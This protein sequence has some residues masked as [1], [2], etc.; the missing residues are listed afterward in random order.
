MKLN[1]NCTFIFMELYV[2]RELCSCNLFLSVGSE[3]SYGF[4][5]QYLKSLDEWK[6]HASL[7]KE[8]LGKKSLISFL[9]RNLLFPNDYI[10][11]NNYKF[12]IYYMN[13]Y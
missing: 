12:Y 1:F 10:K 3:N 13:F 9:F 4:R 11:K 6:N 5:L 7:N 8:P 2:F